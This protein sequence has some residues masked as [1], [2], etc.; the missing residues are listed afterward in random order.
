[1]SFIDTPET[2]S[3]STE[4]SLQGIELRNIDWDE[5]SLRLWSPLLE[6]SIKEYSE[7]W[8]ALADK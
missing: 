1:M 7:I 4:D 8:K 3:V 5:Y 2:D 6:E